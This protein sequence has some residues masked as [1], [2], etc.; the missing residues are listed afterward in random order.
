MQKLIE[1]LRQALPPVFLGSAIDELTGGAV[2]WG[3]VQ[4]KRCRGEIPEECFVRS[5]LR[6]IVIR[7]RFLD[8]WGTTLRPARETS[9]RYAPQPRAGRR[10]RSRDD[11][12]E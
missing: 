10:Q 12:A 5:G 2:C 1:Q 11:L 7:D 8:W 9:T 6:V 3:T 4:N